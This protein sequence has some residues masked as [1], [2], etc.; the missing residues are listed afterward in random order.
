VVKNHLRNLL[1][2]SLQKQKNHKLLLQQEVQLHLHHLIME[3][4]KMI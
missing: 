4:E 3:K 1:L 2:R